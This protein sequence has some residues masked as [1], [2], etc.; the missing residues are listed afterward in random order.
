M[1]RYRAVKLNTD[2]QEEL[3]VSED[4]DNI[5]GEGA[6]EGDASYDELDFDGDHEDHHDSYDEEEDG[7]LFVKENEPE[8]EDEEDK[9]TE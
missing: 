9:E 1:K 7:D 4:Y 6:Y 5:S 3:R 2:E 8:Y